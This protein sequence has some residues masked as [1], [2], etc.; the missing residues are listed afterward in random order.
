M[1]REVKAF[2]EINEDKILSWDIRTKIKSAQK[3]KTR[4]FLPLFFSMSLHQGMQ[5]CNEK[6]KK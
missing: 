4:S 1:R 5:S 2:K 3:I 6:K